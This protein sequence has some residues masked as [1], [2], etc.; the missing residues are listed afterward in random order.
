MA[1]RIVEGVFTCRKRWE[2]EAALLATGH[3][4]KSPRGPMSGA[5]C[6]CR[7]LCW[8][9]DRGDPKGRIHDAT[10]DEVELA[11]GWVGKPGVLVSALVKSGWIDE[12]PAGMEWH[13]Y[14]SL[15]RLTLTDRLKKQ[16]RDRRK[17][18]DSVGGRPRKSGDRRGDQTGDKVGDQTGD[19]TPTTDEKSIGFRGKN[20]VDFST[21]YDPKRG[22]L[23]EAVKPGFSGFAP[24]KEGDQRGDQT[25][26]Q[27][28]DRRGAKTGASESESG[29]SFRKEFPGIGTEAPARAVGAGAGNQTGPEPIRPPDPGVRPTLDP[30]LW[31]N[32]DTRRIEVRPGCE[33][34][35]KIVS[36]GGAS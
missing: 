9:D 12:T 5:E 7:V 8:L 2:L 13:D 15:N 19:Q 30:R 33:A 31:W 6:V 29:N 22:H 3:R 10:A 35:P 32:P 36:T 4:W 28:G 26:D 24:Q 34:P 11:A 25:R 1:A 18:P 23:S 20:E 17:S 14:G 27:T 21:E 16:D